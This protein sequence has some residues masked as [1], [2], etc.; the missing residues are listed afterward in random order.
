[1]PGSTA[2]SRPHINLILGV[3]LPCN[4]AK[5]LRLMARYDLPAATDWNGLWG[6]HEVEDYCSNTPFLSE[7]LNGGT[8]WNLRW[9]PEIDSNDH[10]TVWSP[11]H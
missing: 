10:L 4:P 3:I 7:G 11:S 9:S 2:L 1:M 5:Q 6:V 8:H